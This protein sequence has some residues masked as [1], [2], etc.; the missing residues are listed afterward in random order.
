MNPESKQAEVEIHRLMVDLPSDIHNI[1]VL[2][3][4]GVLLVEPGARLVGR[5]VG[6]LRASK[7]S[8]EHRARAHGWRSS[9]ACAA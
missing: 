3:E 9:S 7:R 1:N 5:A 8:P 6:A 2:W 4:V